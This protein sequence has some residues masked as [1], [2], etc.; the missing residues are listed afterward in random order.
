MEL[1]KTIVH[2]THPI[3]HFSCGDVKS[4]KIDNAKVA[5]GMLVEKRRDDFTLNYPFGW[6]ELQFA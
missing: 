6:E 1:Y 4:L 3:N 2:D 5:I